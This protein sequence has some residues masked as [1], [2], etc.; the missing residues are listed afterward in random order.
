MSFGDPN[1]PYG[2]PQ[3]QQ[4]G[5]Y[6]QPQQPGYGQQPGGYGQPQ[7]QP[8]YGQ[9]QQGPPQQSQYGYPQAPPVQPYDA[10][11]QPGYG[12]GMPELAN[13]GYR[14]GA[15]LIDGLISSGPY[16]ALAVGGSP[17]MLLIGYAWLIAAMVFIAY[18]EGTTGQSPG[19]QVLG[20]KLLREQD[21]QIVGFGKAFLR[22][23]AHIVDALPCY[24]GYLWP[25]WDQK[26]QTFADKICST[27][28]IKSN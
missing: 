8:G 22:R 3:G 26:K 25:A 11:Q 23:L 15:G 5:G 17:T 18:R 20:I 14:F 27:V 6:G 9:P 21:G 10:Y 7:G 13:W 1:N 24:I 2:Q 4:P 16:L 28:V 19:K 12:S